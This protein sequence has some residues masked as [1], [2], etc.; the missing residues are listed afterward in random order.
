M[1]PNVDHTAAIARAVTQVLAEELT[2]LRRDLAAV[3][4]T[5]A[6][7]ERRGSPPAGEPG[8]PG[9][10]GSQGLPGVPGPP[11]EP[12]DKGEPGA[13]GPAGSDGERGLPGERGERGEIGLVGA[14]GPAGRDGRD[15]ERGPAG[16]RGERGIDGSHGLPGP[17]GEM[18]QEGRTGEVGPEGPQGADGREWRWTGFYEPEKGYL[19][20]DVVSADG[21]G[22]VATRDDPGPLPGEGWGNFAQRGKPGKPGPRGDRGDRGERGMAGERGPGITA[23][24]IDEE[25]YRAIPVLSDGSRAEPLDLR[26]LFEQFQMETR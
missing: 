1:L 2:L 13:P 6:D 14:A 8:P 25:A 3:H 23:W 20:G 18:G 19:R 4:A 11:G 15:G 21:N 9:E 5:L 26:R 12:G 10:M 22:F 17:R 16:D 24:I 7:L